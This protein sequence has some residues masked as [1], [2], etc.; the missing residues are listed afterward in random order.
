LLAGLALNLI[1]F[2]A[3]IAKRSPESLHLTAKTITDLG[4]AYGPAPAVITLL[5]GS[6]LLLYQLNRKEHARIS[7]ELK[8]RHGSSASG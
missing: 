3:D 7:V 1:G 2:P 5:G 6:L 4:W 8:L